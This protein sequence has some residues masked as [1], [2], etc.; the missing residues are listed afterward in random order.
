MLNIAVYVMMNL[1]LLFVMSEKIIIIFC[2]Q[3]ENMRDIRALTVL[4]GHRVCP[5]V[6]HKEDQRFEV[7]K[8]R[9]PRNYAASMIYLPK[10]GPLTL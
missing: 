7:R 6:Q 1:F 10:T 4:E 2:I 9:W 8:A 5:Y 3:F